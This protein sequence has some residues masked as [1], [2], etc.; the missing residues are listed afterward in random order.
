MSEPRSLVDAYLQSDA[1]RGTE[2]LDRLARLGWRLR[3]D[4]DR[5]RLF[6]CTFD[7][8]IRELRVIESL[9]QHA[10]SRDSSVMMTWHHVSLS[11]RS[12]RLPTWAELSEIKQHFIGENVEAYVV[13]PPPSRYVDDADVLHLWACKSAPDG[14]LP[15][16]R[17]RD[18][19][20][21]VSI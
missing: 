4:V 12:H 19:I 21:R 6:R 17:L 2:R 15:D 18:P 11:H 3:D 7:D 8:N 5:A 9:E 14:L 10:R 1:L 20:G 13:L 16:F